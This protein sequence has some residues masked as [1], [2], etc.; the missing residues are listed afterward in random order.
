MEIKNNA[1]EVS[2]EEM[3]DFC[4]AVFQE[5]A[6]GSTYAGQLDQFGTILNSINSYYEKIVEEKENRTTGKQNSICKHF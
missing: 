5:S 6:D 3:Q 1:K 2:S 4:D